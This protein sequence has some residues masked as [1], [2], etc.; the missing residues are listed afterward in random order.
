MQQIQFANRV[1]KAENRNRKSKTHV[2]KQE[3]WHH[4]DR[5]PEEILKV[6]GQNFLRCRGY[7]PEAKSL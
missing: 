7:L 2:K 4:I 3:I 5:T 6:R 1:K